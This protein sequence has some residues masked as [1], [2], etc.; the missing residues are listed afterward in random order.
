MITVINHNL[1]NIGSVARALSYLNVDFKLSDGLKDIENASKIVFPGVGSY[2]AAS[3]Q[4]LTKE[5]TE[6]VRYKVLDQKTPF[7]GFCLGMQLLTEVGEEM[8]E[9]PGLGLVAGR[10]KK[11][12]VNPNEFK[13][14]HMGWND[15]KSN[16]LS[17]FKN[18]PDNSCFYFV[19]SFEVILEDPK[20]KVS[21]VN[22]GGYDIVAAIE[23]DNIWGAQFH[24]EKSQKVGLQVLKNFSEF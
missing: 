21:T 9:S 23:K 5:F 20:T 18:V 17:M 24:P 19:H 3:R 6:I 1:G 15:V 8:W 11:L 10:T 2:A 13:V 4:V 7:F 12:R 22:Y 14:P 16:G